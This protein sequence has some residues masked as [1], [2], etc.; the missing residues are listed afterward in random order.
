M[1]Q[2]TKESKDTNKEGGSEVSCTYPLRNPMKF[3]IVD[4]SDPNSVQ[5]AA[6]IRSQCEKRGWIYDPDQPE[7]ILCIGGDGTLLRAIHQYLEQLDR[8]AFIGIHTGTLGFFTD[9]TQQEIEMFLED[10]EKGEPDIEQSPLLAMKLEN[11]ETIYSL[12]EMRIESFSKTLIL[13]IYLDHEFFERATGSGI[14]VSS[15]A[16]STAVNRAL[17][18][19]VIDSGLEVMQLCEIMP[20]SHKNHH[21]LRNPYIMNTNRVITILS[22]ELGEA[23]VCYDHLERSLAGNERVEIWTSEKKVRF[24]RYRT[25]S[26]L[27][28]LKNLY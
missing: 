23:H 10:I 16:G 22:K 15:Q 12:N 21:S 7:I 24:A 27:K 1:S 3:N 18:G 6:Y 8:I 25:Y 9:Y 20:I 28:R 13:D 19:A 14:C 17:N 4:R 11:R 2:I 26:Y 5:I